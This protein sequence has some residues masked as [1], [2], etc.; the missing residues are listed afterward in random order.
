V[1]GGFARA[2]NLGR[3]SITI[4]LHI[5]AMFVAF[6]F[7]TGTGIVLSAIANNGDVR[8]IRAAAKAT[9]P[10]QIA[11]GIILIIGLI[12]GFGAAQMAGFNLGARW[13]VV[14]YVCVALLL[15]F[16]LVVHRGWSAKLAAAAAASPENTPS[17]ELLAVIG[18]PL[19]RI[20]GPVSGILWIAII[21]MMVVKPG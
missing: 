11:G 15:Y 17:A 13:L 10:F 9:R 4:V 19:V 5:L 1:K 2:Q 14:T 16:G 12:F 7:T 20:A 6:A 18:D 3:M 21:A 8:A